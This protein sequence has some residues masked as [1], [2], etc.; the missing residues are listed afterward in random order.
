MDIATRLD[1]SMKAARLTD[2]KALADKAGL[3]PS[4]INRILSGRTASVDADDAYK[5][6]KACRVSVAWL[7]AGF[8]D[9]TN[10]VSH[11]L[12]YQD[13]VALIEKY[14]ASNDEG[15]ATIQLSADIAMRASHDS[16]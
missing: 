16:D 6:A 4:K 9:E 11:A 14:R 2:Q 15:K 7:I 8:E 13:E 12:L 1:M 3:S 5:L 10:F